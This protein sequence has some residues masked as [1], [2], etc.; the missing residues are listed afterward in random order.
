MFKP[1]K[2]SRLPYYPT[3]PGPLYCWLCGLPLDGFTAWTKDMIPS[4]AFENEL[5]KKA[6]YEYRAIPK[7]RRR[8]F[9][10]YM[11]ASDL[12][13]TFKLHFQWLALFRT[14][15][16]KA[17]RLPIYV[18]ALL[19]MKTLPVVLSTNDKSLPDGYH[20]SGIGYMPGARNGQYLLACPDPATACLGATREN[21]DTLRVSPVQHPFALYYVPKDSHLKAYTV[22]S[23]CWDLIEHK[24]GPLAT[25]RLDLIVAALRKQ[26]DDIISLLAQPPIRLCYKFKRYQGFEDIDQAA[27][28]MFI[29][30]LKPL[31]QNY[32]NLPANPY[33]Q[34]TASLGIINSKYNIPLEITYLIVDHLNLRDTYNMLIAFGEKLP[35]NFWKRHIP[36]DILF[37]FERFDHDSFLWSNI[38]VEIESRGILETHGIWN[39]KRVLGMLNPIKQF[40]NTELNNEQNS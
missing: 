27:D 35:V 5:W 38:A 33:Q 1:P 39:R 29:N 3:D 23:R 34:E 8:K 26:W 25:S 24:I 15:M 21:S 22:H 4:F 2:V 28:P 13:V 32:A 11:N 6:W 37:E 18:N 20:L 14:S 9:S 19:T 31:L 7:S 17:T 40:V 10:L 30:E 36:T 16:F 12:D